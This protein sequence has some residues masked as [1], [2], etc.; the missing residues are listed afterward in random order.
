MESKAVFF[1]WLISK[2]ES[3]FCWIETLPKEIRQFLYRLKTGREV[4]WSLA[5]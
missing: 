2:L 1:S 3:V 4:T 5:A